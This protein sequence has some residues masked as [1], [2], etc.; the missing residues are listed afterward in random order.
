VNISSFFEP[1]RLVLILNM[2]FVT[3]VFFTVA[4]LA[5][6]NYNAKGRIQFL[7]S[8]CWVLAFGMECPQ[9]DGK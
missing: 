2:L 7:F 5:M 9:E 8:G 3:A 1:P 4:Y 6:R